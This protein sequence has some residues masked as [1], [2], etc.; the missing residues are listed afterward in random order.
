MDFG[1]GPGA[2]GA[3]GNQEANVDVMSWYVSWSG[4]EWIETIIVLESGV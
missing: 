2:F 1:A 3:M 4:V